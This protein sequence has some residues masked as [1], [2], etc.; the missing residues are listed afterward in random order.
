MNNF[1]SIFGML[2]DQQQIIPTFNQLAPAE[3]FLSLSLTKN[4]VTVELAL[5]TVRSHLLEL[6]SLL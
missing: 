1:L 3:N 6:Q 2:M 4:N 5:N